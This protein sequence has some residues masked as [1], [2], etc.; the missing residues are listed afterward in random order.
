[1]KTEDLEVRQQLIEADFDAGAADSRG[2]LHEILAQI[3]SE[4][5]ADNG[6]FV[7]GLRSILSAAERLDR[8][9]ALE[10]ARAEHLGVKACPECHMKPDLDDLV[11]STNE[12]FVSCMNHEGDV[13]VQGG[14]T[15]S[16]A[17]GKWNRDDWISG[18]TERVLFVISSPPKGV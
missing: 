18:R 9:A 4:N 10:H 3:L 6:D 2:K 15:L 17:I 8:E 11:S 1:M 5:P 13:V 14:A 7:D 12:V 16:E